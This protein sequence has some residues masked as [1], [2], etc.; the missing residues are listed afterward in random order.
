M[1][2]EKPKLTARDVK[3]S[4]KGIKMNVSCQKNLRKYGPN[5]E[6]SRALVT[7]NTEKAEVLCD[8]FA[9]VFLGNTSL[10]KSQAL[11]IRKS[12]ARKTHLI[13]K[14]QVREYLNKLVINNSKVP[15]RTHP[16]VLRMLADFIVRSISIE[17]NY[18]HHNRFFL[19]PS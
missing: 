1:E 13:E 14:D 2:L 12:R 3:G 16:Q 15:D 17:L 5:A 9:S 11:E 19:I 4:K 18:L 8:F 6:C 10:Q 7:E